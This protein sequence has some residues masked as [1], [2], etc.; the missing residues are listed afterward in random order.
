MPKLKF[1]NIVIH[2]CFII[3]LFFQYTSKAHVLIW[4]ASIAVSLFLWPL[5]WG[6]TEDEEQS[7]TNKFMKLS[8]HCS[9]LDSITEPWVGKRTYSPFL[10]CFSS[11]SD[12]HKLYLAT[13]NIWK[14]KLRPLG[15]R[16]DFLITSKFALLPRF[17]DFPHTAP[18]TLTMI[19]K[20]CINLKDTD[21]YN[22]QNNSIGNCF[23]EGHLQLK[24]I[25]QA[26]HLRLVISYGTD[27]AL[28]DKCKS[29]L[30]CGN[31]AFQCP[32]SHLHILR[33]HA[34]RSVSTA[35]RLIIFL[36]TS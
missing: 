29:F 17:I 33:V 14:G 12:F 28:T 32:L 6:A 36:E 11:K 34:K 5:L 15:C 27:A 22:R 30:R 21:W 3:I 13:E 19:D 26:R 35:Y 18:R 2:S 20:I 23:P 24:A 4:S 10:V 16:S 1:Y 9:P 8:F 7:L 31:M 25:T